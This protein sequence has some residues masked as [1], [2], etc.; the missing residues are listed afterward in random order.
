[1]KRVLRIADMGAPCKRSGRGLSVLVKLVALGTIAAGTVVCVGIESRRERITKVVVK[2]QRADYEG[3]R[4]AL[5]RLYQDLTQFN[6]DKEFGA[7]V[8][9]WRGFAQW[10]RAMNGVNDSVPPGELA[11]DLKQAISEFEEA[12]KKDPGF[13]DARAAAGSSLGILMFIYRKNPTLAP[14]FN[15]PTRAR[16]LILKALSYQQEAEAADPQNPRVLWVI[17]QTRWNLPPERGGGQDKTFE[18]YEKG[19]NAARER[20]G[21]LHD[22][23]LPSWGEAE[24][25]MN[26]AWS[27]LNRS[28]PDLAAAEQYA[29]AALALV[30]YW[31]YVRDILLPQIKAAKSK[32]DSKN[33]TSCTLPNPIELFQPP[34]RDEMLIGV[35]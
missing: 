18:T 31:H 8:R 34:D 22:P 5:G 14:E 11:Q 1:M 29:R 15:D 28:T 25:L 3:D 10:R 12:I 7:R 33:P 26:L 17:G 13:V 27:N 20:K 4:V 21:A 32:P 30:P 24:I 23:L 16:E 35:R 9:Y 6:D 19:L 2:I